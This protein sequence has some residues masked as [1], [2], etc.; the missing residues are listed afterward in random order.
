MS[1]MYYVLEVGKYVVIVSVD[2]D[3]RILRVED[4]KVKEEVN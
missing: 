2:W 4:V 3:K 1:R